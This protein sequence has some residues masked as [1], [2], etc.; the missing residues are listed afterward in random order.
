MQTGTMLA[1][2]RIRTFGPLSVEL[3]GTTRH[4]RA[5]GAVK[6]RAVLELLVLAQGRPVSKDELAHYLWEGRPRTPQDAFRT[7]EHYVCVLRSVLGRSRGERREVI[8][9]GPNCYRLDL[10]KV[11]LDVV[12]FERLL[13]RADLADRDERR[14]LLQQAVALAS[15]DFLEDSPYPGW[16]RLERDRYRDAVARA[17]LWLA[18]DALRDGALHSAVQLC[19]DAL[20]F[21]PFSEHAVRLQ[22]VANR[23]LG[24]DD[25]ARA[26]YHRCRAVLARGLNLDPTSHTDAI[27]SA[28]DAGVSFDELVEMLS[29]RAA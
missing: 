10:E 5:L 26:C 6:T 8:V 21:A 22:M 11:D 27:A 15:G 13:R 28:V 14:A 17:H 19:D 20:R 4:G 29:L 1:P 2:A 9:T 7:L 16:A 24:C 12:E 23:G 25:I 3:D 18:E